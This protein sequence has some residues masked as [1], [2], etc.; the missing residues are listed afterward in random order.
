MK[1]IL[2]IQFWRIA[3]WLIRKGYGADCEVSDIQELGLSHDN[4]ARC[5]SCKAK[6]VIGWIDEHISLL[7]P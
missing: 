6:E 5:S 2:E 7:R 3:K 4:P 1:D